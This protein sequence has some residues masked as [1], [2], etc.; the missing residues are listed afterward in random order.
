MFLTAAEDVA[1]AR[2]RIRGTRSP[3]FDAEAGYRLLID[4]REPAEFE[5]GDRR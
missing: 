5:T 1:D 2:R 4:V 3:S